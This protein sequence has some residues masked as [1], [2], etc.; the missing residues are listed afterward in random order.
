MSRYERNILELTKNNR[1]TNKSFA[2]DTL[3]I[4]EIFDFEIFKCIFVAFL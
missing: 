4:M 1:E 2:L 3:I